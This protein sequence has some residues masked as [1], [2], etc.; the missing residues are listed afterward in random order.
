[1]FYI[2]IYV[3]LS[4]YVGKSQKLNIGVNISAGFTPDNAVGTIGKRASAAGERHITVT[5]SAEQILEHLKET[6]RCDG[7]FEKQG[8]DALRALTALRHVVHVFA[9]VNDPVDGFDAKYAENLFSVSAVLAAGQKKILYLGIPEKPYCDLAY[10]FVVTVQL[11]GARHISVRKHR[12]HIAVLL[13][14][15]LIIIR[16]KKANVNRLTKDRTGNRT[17]RI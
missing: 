15:V 3:I 9:L 4:L 7:V 14:N 10:I 12:F 1:M 13:I 8:K 5:A 16:H 2:M 11:S 6:A 17:T